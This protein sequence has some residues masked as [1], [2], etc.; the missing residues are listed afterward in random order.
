MS[1][2]P[3][4]DGTPVLE[5]LAS[6]GLLDAFMEAVDNDDTDTASKIMRRAGIDAATIRQVLHEM[7]DPE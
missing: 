3:D 6:L 4:F 5:K 7:R 2:H 1:P